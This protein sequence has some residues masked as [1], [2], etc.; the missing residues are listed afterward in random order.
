M[1]DLIF[2]N[3][4]LLHIVNASFLSCMLHPT[5]QTLKQHLA[6]SFHAPS[7]KLFKFKN[8]VGHIDIVFFIETNKL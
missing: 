8:I 3:F 6:I 1:S 7:I 2:S 5:I 4:K